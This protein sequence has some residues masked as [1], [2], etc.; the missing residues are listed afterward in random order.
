M[1]ILQLGL[2][3]PVELLGCKPPN[4]LK[5][6][7]LYLDRALPALVSPMLAGVDLAVWVS[8]NREVRPPAREI[9]KTN[10][11]TFSEPPNKEK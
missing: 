7:L 1:E 9:L 5:D 10:Q 11:S 8:S 6:G 4:W 2:P 3:T